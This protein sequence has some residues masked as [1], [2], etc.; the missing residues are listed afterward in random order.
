MSRCGYKRIRERGDGN[1]FYRC[2]SVHLYSTDEKHLHV[3]KSV[4]DH[5]EGH[6]YM[7]TFECFIDGDPDAH[8]C[9]QRLPR[10]WATKAEILAAADYCGLHIAVTQKLQAPPEWLTFRPITRQSTLNAPGKVYLVLESSHF[11]VVQYTS[12]LL[13]QTPCHMDKE[14]VDLF[15]MKTCTSR[16]GL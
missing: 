15:D 6:K 9:N 13:L 5:L 4:V 8:V 11:D 1:C 10:S 14:I 12:T 16:R 2:I 3:Q 7:Y